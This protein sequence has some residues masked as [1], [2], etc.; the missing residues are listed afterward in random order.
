MPKSVNKSATTITILLGTVLVAFYTALNWRGDID[1]AYIF[2]RYAQHIKDG[3]GYV[4]NIGHPPIEGTT[5]LT[6]TLLLVGF[7]VFSV[8]FTVATKIL[9]GLSVF[10]IL[11]MLG[12]DLH[13][14]A[15]PVPITVLA[16]VLLVFNPVFVSSIMMG[17]ETGLYAAG[18]LALFIVSS[19]SY[20]EAEKG[21]HGLMLGGI[22][23][24]LFLT[25]PESIGILVLIGLGL[26][27]IYLTTQTRSVL[28]PV[29]LWIVGIAVVSL[30]RWF[31]FGD[32]IPNSARAKS[33]L[34]FSTA[35]LWILWPRVQAG[36]LYVTDLVV[37]L[38]VLFV[39][40]TFGLLTQRRHSLGYIAAAILLVG[41]GTVLLNSG[42]WMPYSRL[43]TPYLPLVALLAG[44][45]LN[46]LR[47]R[48]QKQSAQ[49]VFDMSTV[50][51][52]L[53]VVSQSFW[54]VRDRTPFE[55]ATWPSGQCY[56][57]VGE[58]L[59]PNLTGQTVVASEAIGIIGY[60]MLDIPILDIFGLT[61]AEI[62]RHG[63]VPIET[64]TLGKHY[65]E[66]VMQQHPEIFLFHSQ[67]TNHIPLLSQWGYGE[68]YDTFNIRSPERQCELIIGLERTVSPMLQP[69]LEQ[70]F[71]VEW[72]DVTTLEE[73]PA[74]T[75]P[76]GKK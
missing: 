44:I 76:F 39:L 10:A 4:F 68:G 26:V 51:L 38:P 74:A 35:F 59:H 32:F 16:L 27:Y 31:T 43:L 17:L 57:Y 30:W 5:S 11:A 70:H 71:E 41:G 67:I 46:H 73:N 13:R 50:L 52:A 22:G 9:G 40:G 24:L 64:Y 18:V 36:W 65:Y 1:D 49:M 3:Y 72:V 12:V 15:I 2:F 69:I 29:I 62:A 6:W 66:F 20:S 55:F 19:Q 75:W 63:V 45:G 25:R 60:T 61:E 8:P 53:L 23:L 54:L 47:A 48:L 7:A 14:R 37:Q 33:V 42:D 58:V 34:A 28:Y 56:E 21:S